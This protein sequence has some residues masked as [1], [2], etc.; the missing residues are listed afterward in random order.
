M[1]RFISKTCHFPLIF[2]NLQQRVQARLAV[3]IS[4][5][6]ELC[7]VSRSATWALKLAL[8]PELW[9]LSVSQA[10]YV[11]LCLLARKN[12]FS[13]LGSCHLSAISRN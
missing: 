7:V 4:V 1:L 11:T 13:L 9:A 12:Y 5:I 2:A 3:S 10:P 6:S 8:F